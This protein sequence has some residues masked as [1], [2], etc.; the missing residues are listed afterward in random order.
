MKVRSYLKNT[1]FTFFIS[2]QSFACEYIDDQYER[3]R[4]KFNDQHNEK[5]FVEHTKNT[6]KLLSNYNNVSSIP[7]TLDQ[8]KSIIKTTMAKF[9]VHANPEQYTLSFGALKE[10]DKNYRHFR[11]LEQTEM[12]SCKLA[13]GLTNKDGIKTID[14]CL[15][16]D[17][18]DNY[19]ELEE[20]GKITQELFLIWFNEALSDHNKGFSGSQSLE[21]I[22]KCQPAHTINITNAHTF[23]PTSP[24]HFV[25]NLCMAIADIDEKPKSRDTY[26]PAEPFTSIASNKDSVSQEE[27]WLDGSHSRRHPASPSNSSAHT[28][29]DCPSELGSEQYGTSPL[30]AIDLALTFPCAHDTFSSAHTN[31]ESKELGKE[32]NKGDETATITDYSSDGE[33]DFIHITTDKEFNGTKDEE[34]DGEWE[35]LTSGKSSSKKV[36]QKKS[37]SESLSVGA[38]ITGALLK[39]NFWA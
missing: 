36:G 8:K 28:S 13:K 15:L 12:L 35:Q 20:F 18:W 1:L 10:T 27:T 21:M 29:P 25:P 33:G 22:I 4:Q 3:R 17:Q 19:K 7:A 2:A 6:N 38:L 26:F 23:N 9:F 32:I 24:R 11:I 39:V 34:Q 31:D 14:Q 30:T 37:L 16:A 5:A